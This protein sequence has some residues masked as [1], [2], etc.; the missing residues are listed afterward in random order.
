M[1]LILN[2]E[3]DF[4]ASFKHQLGTKILVLIDLA[5]LILILPLKLKFE[6]N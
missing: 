2:L 1:A 5:L 3:H 6:I 4:Q